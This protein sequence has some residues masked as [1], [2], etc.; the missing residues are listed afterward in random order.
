MNKVGLTPDLMSVSFP[1]RLPKL[2]YYNAGH[3]WVVLTPLRSF[4]LCH[5]ILQE[6]CYEQ[7]RT[8]HL[9]PSCRVSL[10]PI[11]T[12]RVQ[13][14]RPSPTPWPK[15]PPYSR[16][17][18]PARPA[19]HLPGSVRHRRQ[20]ARRLGRDR[21][22]ADRRATANAA[23]FGGCGALVVHTRCWLQRRSTLPRWRTVARSCVWRLS[24]SNPPRSPAARHTTA[25][26][27]SQSMAAA[28]RRR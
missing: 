9:S 21:P 15:P 7:C 16:P 3:E 10:K 5:G 24:R 1:G 2:E 25:A 13:H 17:C 26:L 11:A 27:R 12:T 20:T 23:R 14:C 19:Y 6:S 4:S 18:L 28:N 22:G 8:A